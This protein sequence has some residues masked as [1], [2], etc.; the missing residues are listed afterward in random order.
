M[1]GCVQFFLVSVFF[2]S[3]FEFVG[4]GRAGRILPRRMLPMLVGDGRYGAVRTEEVG[5]EQTRG[6][7]DGVGRQFQAHSFVGTC[8]NVLARGCSVVRGDR[9][10]V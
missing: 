9:R 7:E 4:A 10:G 5:K 8:V 2:L 6:N 1:D 3:C